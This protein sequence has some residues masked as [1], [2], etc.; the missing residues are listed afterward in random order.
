[1]KNTNM[2]KNLKCPEAP[3]S[4]K[5]HGWPKGNPKWN[6]QQGSSDKQQAQATGNRCNEKKY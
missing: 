5:P 2:T 3:R 6:K 1:M 4:C